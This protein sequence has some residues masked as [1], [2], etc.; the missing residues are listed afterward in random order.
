LSFKSKYFSFNGKVG[1]TLDLTR[2]DSNCIDSC[3]VST[4]CYNSKGQPIM[5]KKYIKK[6]K[7]NFKLINS[8]KFIIKIRKEILKHN[9]HQIRIFSNGDIIFNDFKKSDIQLK[10][11]FGLCR[12]IKRDFWITTKNQNALF[13]YLTNN[14]KPENLNI[15]LS[16]NK[17]DL[18]PGFLNY[19]HSLK[20]QL[21]YITDNKKE[22]NCLA[23][24]S[25][26]KN[27]SCVDNNCNKCQ[28]YDKN[29]RIWYIHS[30]Y[31]K[32]FQELKLL[33]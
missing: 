4:I 18:N 25:K 22:S 13:S 33:N 15:M 24:K 6:M 12:S 10:N 3:D 16:V 19:C 11:I 32:K 9:L 29:P 20:I 23:S 1:T 14:K 5:N 17:K 28:I 7:R 26:K 2:Q 30:G 21:S 27:N 8:N 31:K